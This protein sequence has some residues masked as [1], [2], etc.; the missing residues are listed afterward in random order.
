MNTGASCGIVKEVNVTVEYFD[1]AKLNSMFEVGGSGLALGGGDSGGPVVANN[2]ALGIVSG[3]YSAYSNAIVYFSDIMAANA[4]LNT[5]IVGPGAPEAITG[6]ASG[7]K[8][9]DATISGQVNPHGMPTVYVVEYG[10][11]SYTHS[12]EPLYAGAGQGFG[13]V[14]VLLSGLEP[15]TTYQY[16]VKASNGLNSGFGAKGTFKTFAWPLVDGNLPTTD[17]SGK[18]AKVRASVRPNK[19]PTTYWFEYG[20]TSAMGKESPLSSAGSALGPVEV[21]QT[22]TNLFPSTKYYYRVIVNSSAGLS[23]GPTGNFTTAPPGW[24]YLSRFGSTGT[25]PGQFK[26]T[27]SGVA[28]DAVGNVYVADTSNHRVQKFSPSGEFLMQFGNKGS[29]PGE[30][31]TPRSISVGPEG[32]IWV[33]GEAIG[34]INEYSPTGNFIQ[35]IGPNEIPGLPSRPQSLTVGGNGRIYVVER[36]VEA[37]GEY[38]STPNAEG[39]YFLKRWPHVNYMLGLTTASN[40][41]VYFVSKPDRAVK[42]ILAGGLSKVCSIP[43]VTS[44]AF[45]PGGL[46]VDG[47][48]NFLLSGR[49]NG[50]VVQLSPSCAFQGTFGTE[51]IGPGQM[52]TPVS[53]ALA[54]SGLLFV[55]S[56]STK[57]PEITRWAT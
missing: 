14:N 43:A 57:Y 15:G 45:E 17:I 41:T 42:R 55:G 10:V 24:T 19:L 40:G 12:T 30:L 16:R 52:K 46:V 54:P 25:G 13:S 11:G 1:G 32:H 2:V 34:E 5:N 39:K 28:A 38:S 21:S 20:T 27:I 23:V 56:E 29:G 36:G 47:Q 6:I 50:S 7:I 48:G 22:L 18:Q 53:L 35:K 26:G 8:T 33:G 31:N 49:N 37:I 44:P 3:G 9:Y 4:E 51:G